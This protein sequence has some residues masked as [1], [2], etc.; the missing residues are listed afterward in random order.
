MRSVVRIREMWGIIREDSH[1]AD[2]YTAGMLVL[3]GMLAVV[4]HQSIHGS[5]STLWTNVL[6]LT[7]VA[8]SIV[9]RR[10]TGSAAVHFVRHFYVVPVIY[11]L[12]DQTHLFVTVVHPMDYDHLLIAADRALFGVDPT[13]WLSRFSTPVLTEYLQ[14]CY[15]IFYLLPVAQALELWFR[16][17][18]ERVVEFARMMAFVFFISY[19]LY[20]IMPAI[21]PRFTLHDFSATNR[22][23]PGLWLTENLR[24]IINVGGGVVAG[25]ADP[26]SVVNRDCMPSGHT[27]LT[28]VNIVLAFRFRSRLRYVF[29]CIGSSLI[30]ATIYLRYHYVIDVLVGGFLVL[31]CMPLEVPVDKFLRKRLRF[32]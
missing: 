10:L 20:F 21:G 19:L 31:L 12:Y 16:G 24:N 32:Q 2:L 1:S 3:Y 28:I 5:A 11:L 7:L 14:I 15:F 25:A 8:S 13:I 29:L 18:V 6:V 27:M 4:L 30:F 9:L 26:A 17:D 23:L 22:E